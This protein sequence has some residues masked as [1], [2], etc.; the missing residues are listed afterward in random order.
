VLAGPNA[1]ATGDSGSADHGVGDRRVV[2]ARWLMQVRKVD[3]PDHRAS[4]AS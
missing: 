3:S 1:A 2:V 4:V